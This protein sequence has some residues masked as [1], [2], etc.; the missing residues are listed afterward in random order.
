MR[1]RKLTSS[2]DMM[3]GHNAGDFWHNA[4]EGVGQSVKTRLLLFSGEW[5]L[6]TVEGTPWGGFPLN[7]LV[8]EQGQILA[9]QTEAMRDVAI[10]SRVIATEGVLTVMNYNSQF[11]PDSRAFSVA[12]NLD[13]LYGPV[14]LF[15]AAQPN[16]A[17]VIMVR[18]EPPTPPPPTPMRALP[19]RRQPLPRYID[20]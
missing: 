17:P 7:P 11:D 19:N 1:Y 20:A 5:F 12:M 6:D 3:F 13:T 15:I 16:R 8:V 9:E 18:S 2:G 14:S 4:P 10:L